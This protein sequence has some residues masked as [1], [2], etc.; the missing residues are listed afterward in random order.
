MKTIKSS[1]FI[2]LSAYGMIS[3]Q[4]SLAQ[5]QI[6]C[7]AYEIMKVWK[8]SWFGEDENPTHFLVYDID[9][10][11]TPE[12]LVKHQEN[13]FLSGHTIYLWDGKKIEQPIELINPN[14]EL[15]IG[16][17]GI[18]HELI[19]SYSYD[20]FLEESFVKLN[21]SKVINNGSISTSKDESGE[22]YN[23]TYY[24]GSDVVSQTAF[25]KVFAIKN[26]KNF[27]DF[28][29][30]QVFPEVKIYKGAIGPY[31]ITLYLEQDMKEGF[32]GCYCYDSR[33]NS[34]F[35]LKC[36]Q[37]TPDPMGSNEVIIKEYTASGKNTGTFV[38]TIDGR[39]DGFTGKFTNSKGKSF[40]FDLHE[41]LKG[42]Y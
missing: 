14:V 16:D 32:K 21:K 2:A 40:D 18:I 5:I 1:L 37:N 28:K 39:G 11:G 15:E 9:K 19:R 31:P 20:S 23:M 29:D 12:I 26:S 10:D 36:V 17:G 25:Y 38:G 4:A 13:D 22:D 6:P 3:T 34:F 33:P 7:P 24:I 30:W 41:Q 8:H 35:T 27:R 42:T